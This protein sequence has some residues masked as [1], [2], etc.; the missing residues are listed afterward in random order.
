MNMSIGEEKFS[1]KDSPVVQSNHLITEPSGGFVLWRCTETYLGMGLELADTKENINW[2]LDKLLRVVVK[3]TETGIIK[4]LSAIETLNKAR[5]QKKPFCVVLD[6]YEYGV[7][8]YSAGF[9]SYNDLFAIVPD[10]RLG[11]D[12]EL[13]AHKFCLLAYAPA[14]KGEPVGG[15]KAKGWI[16]VKRYD[17]RRKKGKDY[18]VINGQWVN[19]QKG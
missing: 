8:V 13:A 18:A 11:E 16:L 15:E 1:K 2:L 3:W 19:I 10:Y 12:D 4:A 6:L 5:R 17:I 7:E 9:D 14:A